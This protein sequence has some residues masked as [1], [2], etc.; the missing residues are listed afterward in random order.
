MTRAKAM[1]DIWKS[2]ATAPSTVK[3][4]TADCLARKKTGR[5]GRPVAGAQHSWAYFEKPQNTSRIMPS[6]LSVRVS[7]TR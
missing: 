3:R 2:L 5:V 6:S 1:A 4:C 7:P